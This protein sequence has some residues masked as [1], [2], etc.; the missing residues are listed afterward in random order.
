MY[1][2]PNRATDCQ[3]IGTF[4]SSTIHLQ[5]IANQSVQVHSGSGGPMVIIVRRITVHLLPNREM[6]CQTTVPGL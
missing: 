3:R 1:L 2:L 6:D 5:S 4:N